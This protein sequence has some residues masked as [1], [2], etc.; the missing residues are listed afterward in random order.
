MFKHIKDKKVFLKYI[1]KKL[2]HFDVYG[3][4]KIIINVSQNINTTLTHC[5]IN[6]LRV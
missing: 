4:Y 5:V 6:T 3:Y 2:S 1:D